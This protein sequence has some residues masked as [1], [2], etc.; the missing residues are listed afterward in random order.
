METLAGDGRRFSEKLWLVYDPGLVFCPC[1]WFGVGVGGWGEGGT[2]AINMTQTSDR[3][4]SAPLYSELWQTRPHAFSS[5]NNL[6]R[7]RIMGCCRTFFAPSRHNELNVTEVMLM[8][9]L[10]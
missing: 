10:S 7:E 9:L 6:F 4:I 2:P 1:G 5:N 3:N 8:F